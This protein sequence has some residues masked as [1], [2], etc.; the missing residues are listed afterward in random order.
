M[1]DTVSNHLTLPTS[2]NQCNT[3]VVWRRE[4]DCVNHPSIYNKHIWYITLFVTLL[5]LMY[6]DTGHRDAVCFCT[7]RY[8]V[9]LKCWERDPN[10]RPA[11]SNLTELISQVIEPLA[12]YLDVSTFVALE[13]DFGPTAAAN[14]PESSVVLANL[15][16]SEEDEHSPT[17]TSPP[18]EPEQEELVEE[19]I[20]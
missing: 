6:L 7:H 20:Q 5:L 13:P 3:H 4:T 8:A 11:F 18:V 15:V 16:F 9:M 12:D 10:N 17:Q 14:R 1:T 2:L 19:H